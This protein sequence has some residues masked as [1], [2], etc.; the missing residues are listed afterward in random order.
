MKTFESEF[1]KFLDKLKTGENFAFSRFSDGELFI[2]K[3]ERLVLADNHFIT[4]G[5]SGAGN[6]TKE[7]HKDFDPTKDK[8]YQDRLIEALT[9]RKEGYYK[10]LTGVIDEDISGE[11]SFQFQLDLYGK[12]D[13]EHLSFANVFINNNYPRFLNEICPIL[14]NKKKVFIVNEDADLSKFSNVIKDFRVG[15]NCIINDY[16]L[17]ETLK[18]WIRDNKISDTIFLF[19]ASTL[20]NYLIHECYKEFDNNTYI[21]IGTALTPWMGLEGWKYSRAYLQHWI[22]KH[23][24]KYGTQVDTWS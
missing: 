17:V 24:N 21:D 11:D 2:L 22:L 8:F 6:Y 5:R 3:G 15:S 23:H 12:D 19:S 14:K 20:S 9:Y 4:G 10:G 18:D 13:D 1:N 7:D 16:T